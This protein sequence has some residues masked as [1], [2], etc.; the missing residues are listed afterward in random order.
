MGGRT[1]CLPADAVERCGAAAWD[2]SVVGIR[3]LV[4]VVQAAAYHIRSSGRASRRPEG[5]TIMPQVRKLD[6][7][8]VKT[9]QN[10]GK[11]T[12]KLI[13]EQY[14]AIFADYEVG[15]YGEAVLDEGENRLTVRNRM[16]AA[17]TRRGLG[18]NF[19]RTTGDLLRFQITEAS[20][21][22]GS[23]DGVTPAPEILEA[24]PIASEAPPAPAKPKGKGGRPRK[25]PAA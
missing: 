12:R 16:K 2:G 14:D 23:P 7:E 13:E 20:K 25:N 22:E 24:A 15:E 21:G 17:A 6:P 11:G 5:A 18:I 10:K 9:F 19:R 8:E 1:R 4:P 3:Q